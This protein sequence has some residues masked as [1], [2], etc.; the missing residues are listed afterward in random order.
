M[1][2]V[3]ISPYSDV[4]SLGVRSLSAC[5]KRAGYETVLIFL[6]ILDDMLSKDDVIDKYSGKVLDQVVDLAAGSDLIGLSLMTNYFDKGVQLSSYLGSKLDIPILW[7]GIHPTVKPEESLKYADIVC[8]GE[9]EE[10]IVDLVGKMEAGEEVS[11]VNNFWFKRNGNIIKNP[12]RPLNDDLDSLPFFDYD[13]KDHYILKG[14]TI[15]A[16]N[17]DLLA[18]FLSENNL[19]G[20]KGKPCYQTITA[21]GCPYNCS[22]CCNNVYWTLYKGQKYLRRRSV[23]NII[24]ELKTMKDNFNFLES[25]QFSDDTIFAAPESDIEEFAGFYKKEVGL[26]FYCLGHPATVTEKKVRD[27]IDAGLQCIQIGVE[28]GAEKTKKLYRRSTSNEQILKTASIINGFHG[29]IYPPIYDFIVDNPYETESDLL[30]TIRLIL[31]FPRPYELNVFSLVLF[32]GTEL[33]NKAIED[34]YIRDEQD[35]IYRKR[36]IDRDRNY[37][38]LL[39]S[40]LRQRW[41]PKPVLKVL[42]NRSLVMFVNNYMGWLVRALY[43]TKS[44]LK[45]G[46]KPHNETQ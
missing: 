2:I 28:T 30:E 10:A 27:L 44:L 36:L 16:M 38:N 37:F 24:E 11:G 23:G 7:G 14:E 4:S 42:S 40:L 12:P 25:V 17:K 1:K 32:P 43:S 22:Y 31:E 34:G 41:I 8:I 21:R 33:Y 39:F 26:P 6:P 18:E 9:A 45:P 15:E 35:E 13:L 20:M 46:M 3:L 29:K 19:P 5:L